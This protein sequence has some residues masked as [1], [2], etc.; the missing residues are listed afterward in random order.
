MIDQFIV[1]SGFMNWNL[2][3]IKI[4]RM[5]NNYFLYSNFPLIAIASIFCLES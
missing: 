1:N 5:V 3:H 4:S 2:G